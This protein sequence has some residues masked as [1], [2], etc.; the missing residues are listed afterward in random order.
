M[1]TVGQTQHLTFQLA[2]EEYAIDILRVKEI[3]E[4]GVVTKVPGTPPFIRGVVNLRGSVVPVIDLAVKFGLPESPLTR[5]TCIVIV[6]VELA[7]EPTVMGVVADAVSQVLDLRPE[8]IEPPPPFGT[9]VRVEFL[10]GLGKVGKRFALILDVDRILSADG[11]QAAAALQAPAE[12]PAADA[13][14]L[15]TNNFAGV[16]ADDGAVP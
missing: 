9:R 3:I 1:E 12:A 5:R 13:E 14:R 7:G 16:T 4:Y 15:P 11:L 8:D 10:R 2:S 6:E